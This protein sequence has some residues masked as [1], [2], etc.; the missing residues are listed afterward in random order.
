V[1]AS[2]S[3]TGAAHPLPRE[4]HH[5]IR[6]ENPVIS[7]SITPSQYIY[8]LV[9]IARLIEPTIATE[10]LKLHA[11]S[12]GDVESLLCRHE[13]RI[14]AD[15]QAAQDHKLAADLAEAKVDDLQKALDEA[16]AEIAAM[17]EDRRSE[18]ER[19]RM[20]LLEIVVRSEFRPE[21]MPATRLMPRLYAL[22]MQREPYSDRDMMTAMLADLDA[23][24]ALGL[25]G[26]IAP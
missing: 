23:L 7:T 4:H 6:K 12:K 8:A 24:V 11:A 26:E 20:R 21:A 18:E 2:H 17:V 3:Q 19:A 25:R 15:R 1:H 5:P 22:R 10:D 9:A 14:R 16:R 13:T